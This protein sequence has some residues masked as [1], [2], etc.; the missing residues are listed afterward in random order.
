VEDQP[1]PP[2]RPIRRIAAALLVLLLLGAGAAGLGYWRFTAP[3]PLEAGRTVIIPKGSG[4]E[5]IGRLLEREGVV[6][7]AVVFAGGTKLLAT[8]S[9]EADRPLKAGEYAFA[10]G[11]SPFGAMRQLQEGRTVVRRLTVPEGLTVRQI[12]A[13]VGAAEGLEG[14]AAAEVPPEG[15]LLPET[16]HYSW[17]DLRQDLLRRMR[18]GMDEA[19]ASAWAGRQPDLPLTDP[20]QLMTL[21]SIVEKETGVEAERPRV[22]AVFVNRLKR[23]MRLQSDPTVIYAVTGGTGL[24]DRALSRADLDLDNPF[25]TYRAAALP[26]GPIAN[27]GRASLAAVAKPIA[28]DD[29]YFVADGTGGH[30]FAKTLDE[31]NRNVARWRRLQRERGG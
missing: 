2:R 5:Q 6:S 19:L 30:A 4:L 25:N 3:G 11:I 18:R 14:A 26:P 28:S 13:L 1:S 8:L 23:G 12:L 31:H 20:R 29:L 24:L 27:P 21:A 17:G 7:E 16:Y 22:A 10:A 9:V 15:S